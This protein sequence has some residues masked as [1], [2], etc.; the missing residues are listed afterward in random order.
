MND[1]GMDSF[2]ICIWLFRDW[3]PFS[4]PQCNDDS[5][6]FTAISLV[7]KDEVLLGRLNSCVVSHGV[8]L[9]LI[10]PGVSNGFDV[11]LFA[12]V[13]ESNGL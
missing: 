12:G 4:L 6:F 10:L 2:I 7:S 3:L 8:P 11:N 13:G 9:L 5:R 1:L